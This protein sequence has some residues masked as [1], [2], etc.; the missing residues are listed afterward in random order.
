MAL[1]LRSGTLVFTYYV[2]IDPRWLVI[3]FCDRRCLMCFDYLARTV[4]VCPVRM[5]VWSGGVI[6]LGKLPVPG[7]PANYA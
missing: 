6:V 5:L 2:L 7:R 1:F 3:I 4:V